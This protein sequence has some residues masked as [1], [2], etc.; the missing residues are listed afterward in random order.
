MR[1]KWADTVKGALDPQRQEV[2]EEEGRRVQTGSKEGPGDSSVTIPGL[3][4]DSTF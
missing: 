4:A 1:S 3:R 2:S